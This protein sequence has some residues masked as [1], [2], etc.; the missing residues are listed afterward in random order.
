MEELPAVSSGYVRA[1]FLLTQVMY[2]IF[3]I[4]ALWRI[5]AVQDLLERA[6][7]PHAWPIIVVIAS[8]S[9]GVPIRLYMLS[10]VSFDIKDFGHKLLMIFPGTLVLDE[11]WALSPFLLARQIGIGLALA[12]T[13][14][15]A[16]APFA[17][18]T[19]ILMR[20]RADRSLKS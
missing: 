7:G 3:Y 2:L 16:Y 8:A 17:Q 10:A 6:L 1:L 20:D 18:R 9:I 12:A 14:A 19:L 5:G 4:V 11:L 13:A 15:L